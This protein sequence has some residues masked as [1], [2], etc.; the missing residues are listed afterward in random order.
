[1]KESRQFQSILLNKNKRKLTFNTCLLK[2]H[3]HSTTK[4]YTLPF[5]M[6]Y[7]LFDSLNNKIIYASNGRSS[8]IRT[9]SYSCTWMVRTHTAVIKPLL[10][11]IIPV[12]SLKA[13]IYDAIMVEYPWRQTYT[14]ISV[15]SNPDH[16]KPII[17][18][19]QYSCIWNGLKFVMGK[20]LN[21]MCGWNLTTAMQ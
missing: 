9:A 3:V 20:N 10:S 7:Y 4:V 15:M 2:L 16:C 8:V 6:E 11:M 1:M 19:V 13:I 21:L 14:C 17:P 5:T 12:L 18:Q